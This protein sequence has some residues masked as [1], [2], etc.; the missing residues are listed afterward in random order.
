MVQDL[1]VCTRKGLFR[2][3]H[4][5]GKWQQTYV[6]FLG[7][8]VTA[9]LA[10][11]RTGH[12]YA[13]LNLGHFGA[14]LHRSTN[15]GATWDELAMPALPKSEDKDAPSLNQIWALEAGGPDQ[16][17]LIWA[18][19]LPAAL[20]RNDQNGDGEWHLVEGLWN[21]P[22]RAKW[23]GGG[24][25]DTALHTICVD[26][27]NSS[28]LVI[29]ISCGGV[30]RSEDAGA[31]WV[32]RSKGLFAEYM[33]PE[34]R[35]DP[36][37]QDPHRIVQCRDQPGHFWCQHHNG[38]FYST[39]DLENWQFAGPRFGFGVA[40]HPK[41]PARAWFVPAIKDEVRVPQDGKFVASRTRDGGKTFDTLA[42]GL[43]TG[44]GYDL[45]LRHALDIDGTGDTLAFGSTTGNLYVTEDQG[46]TW[47]AV[48][49]HLPPVHAVRFAA[50]A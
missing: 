13:A 33:P 37:I 14:K 28:R 35:E 26:P 39:N 31:S 34:R 40:V 24:T 42:N 27:R 16:P 46:E 20:F 19:S 30:W 41:E 18:G 8:P 6:A 12:W 2:F 25:D 38:I 17:G 9:F 4:S 50:N 10:D 45:V 36:A 44:F 11:P 29:A 1:F 5:G 7:Q 32:C 49:H 15:Q 22:D 3:Q 48:T 23:F 43:P 21:L 47:R